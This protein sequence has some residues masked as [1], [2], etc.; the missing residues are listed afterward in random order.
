[1]R[2][3]RTALFLVASFLALP[4][5]VNAI[6]ILD[7]AYQSVDPNVAHPSARG[8]SQ[9][10]ID[11]SG[12]PSVANAQSNIGA[13]HAAGLAPVFTSV[14]VVPEPGALSVLILGLGLLLVAR[15]S[16]TITRQH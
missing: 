11:L 4:L 14:M 12:L 6:P 7:A 16:R 5:S 1:M 2:L 9:P 3:A 13:Q 8:G 15:T 10:S